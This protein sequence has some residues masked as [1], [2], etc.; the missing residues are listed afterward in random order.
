MING[1][2]Y[3]PVTANRKAP[4]WRDNS[5]SGTKSLEFWARASTS[6]YLV[7]HQIIIRAGQRLGRRASKLARRFIRSFTSNNCVA[8]RAI[9]AV[10]LC[11]PFFRVAS[12]DGNYDQLQR[13]MFNGDAVRQYDFWPRKGQNWNLIPAFSTFGSKI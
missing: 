8:P 7:K 6:P 13:R 4:G 5:L 9:V 11:E 1:G 2:V 12:Q 10:A 3:S